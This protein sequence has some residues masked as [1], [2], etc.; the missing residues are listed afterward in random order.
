[1][2]MSQPHLKNI[3][4]VD[5]RLG[6]FSQGCTV[7]LTALAFLLNQPVLVLLT[8]LLMA[9]SVLF[10]NAHPYR[11]AYQRIVVP[12]GLIKPRLVEDDPNPHRFAQGIGAVFLFA[13]SL[14][15]F[16]THAALVG[17]ILDLIVFVLAGVNLTTGFCAGCF[18][19]YQLGRVGVLPKVRYE[20]DFH[21]RGV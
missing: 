7:V 16:L 12:L 14:V 6:K 8:A 19:Y 15:L 18:V 17:W 21:W 3:P 5:T 11:L 20:G 1:M 9:L 13:A 2:E 10:P 4:R